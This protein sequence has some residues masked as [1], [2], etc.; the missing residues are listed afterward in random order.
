MAVGERFNGSAAIVMRAT[1]KS[2]E[3]KQK[4]ISDIRSGGI[5]CPFVQ[6]TTHGRIDPTSTSAIAMLI[7]DDENLSS[8]LSTSTKHPS[9]ASLVKDYLGLM[10]AVDNPTPAG[11]AS[12]FTTLTDNKVFVE[13]GIISSRL[14]RRVLEAVARERHGDDGVRIVRLLLDVGKMDEKQVFQFL[15]LYRRGSDVQ[16]IAKV[17]MMPNNAVRPLLSSLSS[18]FLIS[19]Q[20]V[21]RSADRNPTRTFYLWYFLFLPYQ[22]Q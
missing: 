3:A 10:S 8:G 13:F 22:S 7:P 14:R 11:R 4:N 12:S 2:T 1:L 19:T 15:V 20:E 9:N 5:N 6:V 18:D 21:P 16:Q 17:A